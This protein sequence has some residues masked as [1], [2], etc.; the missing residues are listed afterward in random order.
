MTEQVTEKRS[1]PRKKEAY[2]LHVAH[3]LEGK[4]S[5]HR[6]DDG[7][8]SN[9][10]AM[11]FDL[12]EVGLGFVTPEALE[13]S[14]TVIIKFD[15][16][17]GLG[18]VAIRSK[19]TWR[20]PELNRYGAELLLS[21]KDGELLKSLLKQVGK[22]FVYERTLY[23]PDTNAEGNAYFARYFDWQ[24]ETREAY[25]KQGITKEEYK[26]LLKTKTRL[27]TVKAFME[28]HRSL[29]LFDEIR[30]RMTTRNI[31]HASLEMVFTIFNKMTGELAARGY[32]ELAFQ[33]RRG[34][35]IPV[36]PF[37]RR[38]ALLIEGKDHVQEKAKR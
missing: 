35:L 38:I 2:G 14:S 31:R 4:N 20:N 32:Q 23:L 1:N 18:D 37:I 34:R 7:G 33:D 6:N 12:S 24:G 11:L 22:S 36:P 13:P 28:F 10:N 5:L 30:I 9:P 8:K 15:S 21:E 26:T 17:E 29:G 19:I 27:V 3:S 16:G 25:L